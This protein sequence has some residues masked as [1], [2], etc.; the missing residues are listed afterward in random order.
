M[1][2][3]YTPRSTRAH[4]YSRSVKS[5]RPRVES[6]SVLLRTQWPEFDLVDLPESRQKA[7][8]LR[9]NG[10]ILHRSQDESCDDSDSVT[11][12]INCHTIGRRSGA[13]SCDPMTST[14]LFVSA[15]I[16]LVRLRKFLECVTNVVQNLRRIDHSIQVSNQDSYRRS[17]TPHTIGLEA[18]DNAGYTADLLKHNCL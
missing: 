14:I 5:W 13:G 1:F 18:F 3:E 12:G 15:L 11:L 8:Y 7:R 17:C 4:F 16:E 9:A 2:A 10:K 6:F